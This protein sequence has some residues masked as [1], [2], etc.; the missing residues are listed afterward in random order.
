MEKTAL[1]NARWILQAVYV[2][3]MALAYP[4]RTAPVAVT[5]GGTW[6]L[7]LVRALSS[8]QEEHL[9]LVLGTV[10]VIKVAVV[11]ALLVMLVMT[12]MHRAQQ[13]TQQWLHAITHM[14]CANPTTALASATNPLE[15]QTALRPVAPKTAISEECVTALR[16]VVASWGITVSLVKACVQGVTRRLVVGSIVVY[17]TLRENAHAIQA[18]LAQTAQKRVQKQSLE[19]ATVKV[20]VVVLVSVSVSLGGMEPVVNHACSVPGKSPML[21]Y[22]STIAVQTMRHG[23]LACKKQLLKSFM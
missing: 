2:E 19:Y 9:T 20:I 14:E 5:T 1:S 4:T 23:S 6:M 8:V 7:R 11:L 17:V 15:A 10:A 13:R 18:F 22:I 12:A 21:T 3:A 16:A